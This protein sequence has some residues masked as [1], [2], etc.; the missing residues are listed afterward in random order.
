LLYEFNY[1]WCKDTKSLPFTVYGLPFFSI[2]VFVFVFV[3]VFFIIFA[4]QNRK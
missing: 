3:F 4:Q 2:F 1:L